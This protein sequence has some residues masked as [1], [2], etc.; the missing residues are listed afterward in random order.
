MPHIDFHSAVNNTLSNMT[1]TSGV[2]DQTTLCRLLSLTPAYLI[3]DTTINSQGGLGRWSDGFDCLVDVL[4]A[5][6]KKEQLETN[7]ISEASKACSECWSVVG[8][9]SGLPSESR[10]VVRR[11]GSRLKTILDK[12]GFRYRGERMYAP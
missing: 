10:E 5:L 8:S 4:L 9:Y 11:I 2:I 12:D 1:R 3:L 7:T 6:H